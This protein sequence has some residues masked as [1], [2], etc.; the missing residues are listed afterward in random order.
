MKLKM[1]VAIA[2]DGS[3]GKD[4]D[5]LWKLKDDLKMF[6]KHTLGKT[7]IMGRKTFDSLGRLL[8]NRRHVVISRD[9]NLTIQGAVVVHSIDE[10]ISISN[11]EAIVIGG[12]QIYHAFL[13]KVDTV[14]LTSVKAEFPE[15]DTHLVLDTSQFKLIKQAFYP[16]NERNEFAFTFEV[17]EKIKA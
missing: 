4:N 5:L 9:I 3:I 7:I 14:L 13:P 12:A 16:Q 11:D 10:A 17:L 6:K 15:A 1:M 2:S 8:P